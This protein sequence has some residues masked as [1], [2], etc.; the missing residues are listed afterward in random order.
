M[1]TQKDNRAK[2]AIIVA[3]D[4]KGSQKVFGIPTVRRLILLAQRL[5]LKQ[6]HVIGQTKPLQPILYDLVPQERFHPVED[7]GALERVIQEIALD[8]S[9]EVLVLKAN[10]IIDRLSLARLFDAE[11]PSRP[12]SYMQA[13]GENGLER[14]YLSTPSHLVAILRSLWSGSSDL[15]VPGKSELVQGTDGLPDALDGGEEQVRIVEGK[16]MNALAAQTAADDGF[17]AR[18]LSRRVSR[19]MSWRIVRTPVTPNQ[20][21]LGGAGIGMIGALLLALG[22]YWPQLFGSLLFLFC[23]IVDGV[24]GEIARLKMRESP[25]GHHLDIIADNIVHI[26]IFAGLALGLYRGS[27]D[28]VYLHLLWL[29]LGGFALC[30]IAVYQCILKRSPGELEQSGLTL[31]IMALMSNRDFAYILVILALVGRVHWFLI[32]AAGGTYLF[33]ATLWLISFY[34]KRA[35]AD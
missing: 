13:Q 23:I 29:L 10:Q 15:S 30:G 4:H 22:G 34:E 32:G 14:I 16:L 9:Q 31:K 2:V 5:G 18:H 7:P 35:I 27:G 17:L 26:A 20:I 24:D 1:E 11:N 21:T 28:P 6:I 25:F 12:Y 8:Q 19:F 3:P 33:A